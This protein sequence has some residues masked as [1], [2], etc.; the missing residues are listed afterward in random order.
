MPDLAGVNEWDAEA[1]VEFLAALA[2]TVNKALPTITLPE[3]LGHKLYLTGILPT[4]GTLRLFAKPVSATRHGESADPALPA[5]PKSQEQQQ[6]SGTRTG[7]SS[8]RRVQQPAGLHHHDP[9]H[10]RPCHACR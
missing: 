5:H 3:F 9:G 7:W 10:L 6:P 4:N 1:T 2:K 8:G